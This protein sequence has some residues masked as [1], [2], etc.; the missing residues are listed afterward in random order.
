M[1][2]NDAQKS[3]SL[4]HRDRSIHIERVCSRRPGDACTRYSLS[5]QHTLSWVICLSRILFLCTSAL[6]LVSWC[7]TLYVVIR[8]GS[9]SRH[10]VDML[11]LCLYYDLYGLPPKSCQE[12]EKSAKLVTLT[13][14]T[15]CRWCSFHWLDPD[16]FLSTKD[17]N[18]DP[19]LWLS[20]A[21]CRQTGPLLNN[22][23]C[24]FYLETLFAACFEKMAVDVVSLH[25]CFQLRHRRRQQRR[26]R[27]HR[28]RQQRRRGWRQRRQQRRPDETRRRQ[29]VV[30]FLFFVLL[31]VF[32]P[33][34][35]FGT[36]L[37]FSNPGIGVKS[38]NLT[39]G[40][41]KT[42]Y[43]WLLHFKHSKDLGSSPW[44]IFRENYTC[45]AM[46]HAGPF[47]E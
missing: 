47:L 40:V 2:E 35:L 9:L 25:V 14:V 38:I 8:A 34:F 16:F 7:E 23:C 46:G 1:W 28:R 12:F 26:G 15:I 20:A 24:S 27:G 33:A 30:S 43:S 19:V 11:S 31:L 17:E 32:Q 45:I 29:S 18:Y 37:H 36:N 3:L 6:S 42:V 5:H 41:L 13:D 21:G 39:V 22:L 44:H 10:A 4:P